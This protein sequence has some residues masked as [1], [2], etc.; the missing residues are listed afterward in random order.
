MLN[1]CVF[2]L[3][4]VNVCYTPVTVAME[5]SIVEETKKKIDKL[6]VNTKHLILNTQWPDWTTDRYILDEVMTI[7][8]FKRTFYSGEAGASFDSSFN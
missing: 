6:L 5:Q 1:I 8:K 2:N 4:I 3:F 7:T